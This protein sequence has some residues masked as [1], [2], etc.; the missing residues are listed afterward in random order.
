[1]K[2][3]T[4]E[5]ERPG[6]TRSGLCEWCYDQVRHGRDVDVSRRKAFPNRAE[7]PGLY[8]PEVSCPMCSRIVVESALYDLEDGGA[9]VC[10]RCA[11]LIH[12]REEAL[13]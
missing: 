3:P 8:G 4:P 9:K 10:V 2:C 12:E 5:C 11:I 6:V 7:N 1:M 13:A